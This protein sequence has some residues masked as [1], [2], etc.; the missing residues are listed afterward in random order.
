MERIMSEKKGIGPYYLHNFIEPQCGD[1]YTGS[2]H[3]Q[4]GFEKSPGPQPVVLRPLIDDARKD[5]FDA[6]EAIVK[7]LD[8]DW[9][10]PELIAQAKSALAKA[11]R[12]T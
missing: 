2:L 3:I 11:K 9:I 6:L 12:E 8:T 1:L 5:L 10:S 4:G 7:A